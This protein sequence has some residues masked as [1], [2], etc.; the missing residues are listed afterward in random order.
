[1]NIST[2]VPGRVARTA[3]AVTTVMTVAFAGTGIAAAQPTA[4]AAR[5]AVTVAAPPGDL[6]TALKGL[7]P[8]SPAELQRILPS[9]GNS[10]PTGTAAPSI[11]FNGAYDHIINDNS[12]K[13]LAV[14]GGST[15]Q[16]TGLI[17]WPCGTWADRYWH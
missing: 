4:P 14:P 16:G 8:V 7:R 5:G 9:G 1:M 2:L 17:Q 15:T 10:L 6:R 13:C 11:G 3:A 12:N